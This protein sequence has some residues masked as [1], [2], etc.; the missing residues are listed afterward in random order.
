MVEPVREF[1]DVFAKVPSA[2]LVI[3]TYDAPLQDCPKAL[4]VVR[5]DVSADIGCLVIDRLVIHEEFEPAITREFIGHYCCAFDLNLLSDKARKS[6]GF[7]ILGHFR[8]D[9]STAFN[10]SDHWNF[11]RS[12]APLASRG[13]L[14]VPFARFATNVA[15][16]GFHNT[17][18][19]LAL[20][21]HGTPDTHCHV[22]SCVLVHLQITSQLTAADAFLGVQ[23]QTDGKEPLL[24]VELRVVKN[25]INSHAIGPITAVALVALLVLARCCVFGTAIRAHRPPRPTDLLKV[26]DTIAICLELLVNLDDVHGGLWNLSVFTWD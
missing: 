7:E 26:G 21:D 4:Y 17:L 22:P 19:Q 1:I 25:G 15:L 10:Y 8:P 18:K 3:L 14:I 13:L 12:A 2:D 23:D 11:R 9:V 5:V 16:V 20:F 24:K 6:L